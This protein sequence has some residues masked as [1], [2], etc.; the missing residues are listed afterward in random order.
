MQD[1]ERVRE[2]GYAIG[3]EYQEVSVGRGEVRGD[4]HYVEIEAG[5]EEWW[6]EHHPELD[7]AP[8]TNPL[9]LKAADPDTAFAVVN[10]IG[11]LVQHDDRR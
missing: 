7:W 8:T 3:P 2:D 9:F 4:V 10:R 6:R 1:D 11:N 5:K